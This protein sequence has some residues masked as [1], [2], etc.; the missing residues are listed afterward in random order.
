M[1]S[2]SLLIV[3]LPRQPPG[4]TRPG[5]DPGLDSLEIGYRARY[6][7]P[8]LVLIPELF[9]RLSEQL[10]E[11]RVVEVNHRHQHPLKVAVFLTH[12][13]RQVSFRNRHLLFLNRFVPDLHVTRPGF[14]AMAKGFGPGD[15]LRHGFCRCG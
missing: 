4:P 3:T 5:G 14:A 9:L 12:V 1:Q 10:A 7:D 15:Q 2:L 6:R 13:N 11:Q 8:T